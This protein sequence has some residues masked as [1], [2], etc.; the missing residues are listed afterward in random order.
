MWAPAQSVRRC[1]EF[2][3]CAEADS[4]VGSEVCGQWSCGLF[5]DPLVGHHT[6]LTG[7]PHSHGC[8]VASTGVRLHEEW[9]SVIVVELHVVCVLGGWYVSVGVVGASVGV[10]AVSVGVGAMSV[11][12]D[13]VSVVRAS[14]NVGLAGVSIGLAGVSVWVADVSV[15]QGG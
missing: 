6:Q 13:T 1:G 8:A 11:G 4:E 14:L 2:D 9:Y 12:V 3:W 10:G 5:G 15:D 7:L